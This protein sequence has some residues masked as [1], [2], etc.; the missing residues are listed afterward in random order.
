MNKIQEN[1]LYYIWT[2][3][4]FNHSNLT[5]LDGLPIQIDDYGMRNPFSGPDFS[6]AKIKIGDTIWAGNVEMHIFSS[7]WELHN[8]Q[9]DEAYKNVVLHVVFE[10]DKDITFNAKNT[11][12]S[13][14]TLE[15][16]PFI[17]PNIIQTY[18]ALINSKT[19]IPCSNLIDIH[20][21]NDINLWKYSLAT[22]RLW[23]KI[24]VIKELLHSCNQDWETVFYIL[25]S[26]YFGGTAN[27]LPFE[28]LALKCP[29]NLIHKNLHNPKTVEALFFGQAG[30]LLA[31]H[32]DD[33]FQSL[34]EEYQFLCIKY[35]LHPM[36][37]STWKFGG[38]RPPGF[39][40][41]RI[42]QL[43]GLLL[44]SKN[45]F[46]RI[47]EAKN[48]NQIY[49]LFDTDINEYWSEHYLFGKPSKSHQTALSKAFINRIIINA[50]VPIIFLYGKMMGDECLVD[51][52]IELLESIQS[53]NNRIIEQWKSLGF[54]SK[55]A[56]ESQALIHLKT[57][58]CDHKKCMEC[59][60]GH[61]LIRL[62]N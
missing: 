18:S 25:L 60:I 33:Y 2:T 48:I 27:K 32:N 53:E 34:R 19:W 47:K 59:K 29:L 55:N 50:V 24:D 49:A 14:P 37:V 22:Q 15:L 4:Q 35:D 5:T 57:E 62:S 3:K 1:L 54:S 39:P 30:F 46:S 41:I 58:Y 20:R 52:S 40:T 17:H 7:D 42:A 31:N 23:F 51:Q 13:I 11:K 10:H 26:K 36:E 44:K 6:D 9:H 61:K 12:H 45:L 38:L 43:I 16:K 8:H 28:Q 21:P 56:L